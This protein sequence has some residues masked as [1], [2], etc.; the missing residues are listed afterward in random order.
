MEVM[1]LN[2]VGAS[3]FFLGFLC[4]CLS[5]F[6]T[7]KIT[8][9][10]NVYIK[11][12]LLLVATLLGGQQ[13]LFVYDVEHQQNFDLEVNEIYVQSLWGHVVKRQQL[14]EPLVHGG[15]YLYLRSDHF[16]LNLQPVSPLFSSFALS[17]AGMS[18]S[19]GCES[20]KCFLACFSSQT[21]L[22]AMFVEL[23]PSLAFVFCHTGMS[24]WSL[25]LPLMKMKLSLA[26]IRFL[27]CFVVHFIHT[28]VHFE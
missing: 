16:V 26:V 27:L 6:T 12:L 22:L 1:G 3:E 7:A 8:F 13:Q 19:F 9:T 5:Y 21:T 14:F 24:C 4:N 23:K 25:F 17:S 10:S 28:A 15:D 11:L 18:L 2:P 20:L